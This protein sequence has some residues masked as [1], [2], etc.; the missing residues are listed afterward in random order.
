MR[1]RIAAVAI[2]ALSIVARPSAQQAFT[3]EELTVS[4]YHLLHGA[5]PID[6]R[7]VRHERL[8]AIAEAGGDPVRAT[9]HFAVA[10]STAA[11]LTRDLAL[12]SP[13]CARARELAAAHELLDVTVHMHVTLGFTR[14]WALNLN[15]AIAAFREAIPMGAGLDPDNPDHSPIVGAHH[16]LGA[17]LVETGRFD[18]ARTEITFARDHCRTAGNSVCAAYTDMVLCRLHTMLGDFAPARS[19][20]DAAAAEAAIDRDVIVMANL[21]WMVGTLESFVGRPA[22]SLAALQPAWTAAQTRGGEGLRPILAQL[23]VDALIRLNRLD[24]AEVWQ[25]GLDQALKDG[26]IPFPFGPQIAMRRGQLAAARGRLDEA[27]AAFTIGSRSLIHEMAIRGHLAVART[28]GLRGNLDGARQSLERAITRIEASRSS[29]SG[30]S[31]R[32]A[33]LTLHA[34][35]YRALAG[36]RFDMAGSD[37]APA[38]LEI[39]EA[40]RA[41]A[42]VDTLASAQVAGTAAPKLTAQEL[43]AL[44]G[45][46]DV[47]VEYVSTEN[48]LLAITMTRDRIHA[49]ALPGAGTA[50]ELTKR[51]DFFSALVQEGDD[52]SLERSAAR[53]YEDLLAPALANVPASART[54]I[55]AADG[56]LHRLP[57]DAIGAP[58]V[59]DRWNVVSVPSASVLG[60]PAGNERAS[61]ALIVA[62]SANVAGLAPLTAAGEEADAIRARIGG[63]VTELSGTFATRDGVIR[64][65]LDQFAVLHFASHAVVNEAHPLR[66]ALMLSGPDGQWTAEEIYRRKLRADLVVLSACSTAAGA[67][68]AGEGVMSLSRAFLSAGARATVAT[69]WDV[70]DAPGPLFADVLYRRLAAGDTLGVAAA[71]A[72]RELRRR[73][74]PPRAWAAYVVTGNPATR[75]GIRPAID[76]RMLAAGVT[77]AI[78]VLLLIA[79]L[80][81]RATTRLPRTVFATTSVLFAVVALGLQVGTP[82]AGSRVD[83]TAS[84]SAGDTAVAVTLDNARLRWAAAPAADEYV[85]EMFD[86]AGRHVAAESVTATSFDVPANGA[87]WVRVDA[88]RTGQPLARSALL[89]AAK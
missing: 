35:T 76:R 23:I 15:G 39:A 14:L 82:F 20:C 42:L 40:G 88:R 54:L 60:R 12:A 29:V 38:M 87:A 8:A 67:A 6:E 13:A 3:E 45:P 56:P 53:L 31:L 66:S 41:R 50:D 57:F 63:E 16:G 10:C 2:A 78:A 69:L 27:E 17:A 22:A 43:Q 26:S 61:G 51:V 30:S 79:A 11:S 59:I 74:A 7:V 18:E 4:P 55:I 70:P 1:G 65:P 83:S 9:R 80:L 77:G 85:V 75:V 5:R 64:Q 81:A 84:R 33:Y 86:D 48:R 19:A 46:D 25:R 44:I 89:R 24:E 73:G 71:E 49:L 52:A 36:V 37:A 62:A 34:N 58:R 28:S 68:E 47:L 21:G 32:A 72:R